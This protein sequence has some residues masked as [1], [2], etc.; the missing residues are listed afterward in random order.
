VTTKDPNMNCCSAQGSKGPE[1]PYQPWPKPAPETGSTTG[2]E[3]VSQGTH[4]DSYIETKQGYPAVTAVGA[5]SSSG[6]TYQDYYSDLQRSGSLFEDPE[7]P[8]S[9]SILGPDHR[10]NSRVI[11]LRPKDIISNPKFIRDDATRFDLDQGALGDCWFIAASACLAVTNKKLFSRVVPLEQTFSEPGYCGIFRFNFWRYEQFVEVVVD[12]RLPTINGKLLYARNNEDQ[13]EFWV[14][15]LEKAYA[16]LY[17]GYSVLDGGSTNDALVDLT[18]GIS[19]VLTL[20]KKA[21]I[22]RH[23]YTLMLRT[24]H[25]NSMLACSIRG[26]SLREEKLTTG[27]YRTHAYSITKIATIKCHGKDFKMLR[28]R[29]P[30]GRGE[31]NGAWSDGSSEWKSLSG[32]ERK[33]LGLLDREDGEFWIC[34]EDWMANFDDL[35]MC[36]LYPDALTEEISKDMIRTSWNSVNYH[37]EWV[38]GFNAG[39]CGNPPHEKLYWR[40]PQFRIHLNSAD[41]DDKDGHCTMI[42]SLLQKDK[43]RGTSRSIAYQIYKIRK[44][45]ARRAEYENY[46]S[47]ELTKVGWYPVYINLREVTGRHSLETGSYVIIPSTFH[48][49]N[50]GD[51][52]M[53]V[54]TEKRADGGPIDEETFAISADNVEDSV[55]DIFLRNSEGGFMDAADLRQA[56]N[57]IFNKNYSILEDFGVER[58]RVLLTMMDPSTTGMLSMAEFRQIIK[59]IEKWQ[60]AFASLDV[61]DSG[62]VDTYELSALFRTIGFRLSNSVMATIVKRYGGRKHKLGFQDFTC[63]VAKVVAVFG[64]FKKRER[65]N[66]VKLSLD[67]W[68]SLTLAL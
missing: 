41:D 7:F 59:D 28:L 53:R 9:V 29:N 30:W 48:P 12:D 60:L 55:E 50:E 58:S 8:A 42:V 32:D 18:G 46:K 23:L 24:T 38:T 19:E 61:D 25:M 6:R 33:S 62:Q 45:A 10:N 2:T 34:Y 63:L 66:T 36:H 31:W 37:A 40:N 15:L 39:G 64:V 17:G 57:E 11:W 1:P 52:V 4:D 47:H 27:L 14:A 5:F 43:N 51:F 35:Q 26:T 54:Y 20:T 13:R 56:L 49:N 65:L 16:K 3:T 21:E 22:P 68:M 44:S 67:E